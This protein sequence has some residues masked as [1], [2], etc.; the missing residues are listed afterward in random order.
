M[1]DWA[2]LEKNDLMPIWTVTREDGYLGE[3]GRSL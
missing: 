2:L 3:S 1:R